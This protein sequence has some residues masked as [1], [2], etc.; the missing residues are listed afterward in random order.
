MKP[1]IKKFLEF[2][3]KTIFFLSVDGTYWIALKP[4]C[5]ALGVDWKNQREKLLKDKILAQL[6]SEQSMVAADGRLRKMISLPEFYMYGWLFQIQSDAQ[7]LLEYKWECYR[8]LY[9]YFHGSIIHRQTVLKEKTLIDLQ[10][11]ELEQKLQSSDLAQQISALKRKKKA[12]SS[13]LTSLDREIVERQ[14]E[15]WRTER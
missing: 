3:G 13:K 15:L 14:L 4:I 10:I 9:D 8:I 5:E 6:Y 11:E 2:N 7:G 1:Q 12:A